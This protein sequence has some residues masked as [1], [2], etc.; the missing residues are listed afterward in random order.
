MHNMSSTITG[1]SGSWRGHGDVV[2]NGGSGAGGSMGCKLWAL[3]S[4]VRRRRR[5]KAT[6]II[7]DRFVQNVSDRFRLPAKRQLLPPNSKSLYIGI[8]TVWNWSLKFAPYIT[9]YEYVCRIGSVPKVEIK[10]IWRAGPY[11]VDPK[12]IIEIQKTKDGKQK[13]KLLP[14]PLPFPIIRP[15]STTVCRCMHASIDM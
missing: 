1:E 12:Y 11:V 2:V 3:G 9:T 7:S 6:I 5:K 4:I 8:D 13:Q 14:L 10:R 15:Y